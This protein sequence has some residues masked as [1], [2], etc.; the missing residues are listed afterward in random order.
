MCRTTTFPC[1]EPF[2]SCVPSTEGQVLRSICTQYPHQLAPMC[3]ARGKPV[4]FAIFTA[5]A[6]SFV[7]YLGSILLMRSGFG[8]KSTGFTSGFSSIF[9]GTQ[10]PGAGGVRSVGRGVGAGGVR[11]VGRGVGAG[12]VRSVGRGVGTGGVRSP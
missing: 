8:R 6:I 10:G 4:S 7:S 12:G 1:R 2:L 5:V 11:S 3:T 9:G